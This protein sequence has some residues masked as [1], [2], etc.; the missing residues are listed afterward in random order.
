MS[1]LPEIH[2]TALGAVTPVGLTAA[3]SCAALRA[4]LSNKQEIGNFAVHGEEFDQQPAVGG[5]VPLEWLDGEP[6]PELW[7]GHERW[8][9]KDPPVLESIIETGCDRLERLAAPA[10]EDL[11]AHPGW[12]VE[13]AGKWPD[14]IG[15]Y[16]GLDD[17]EDAEAMGRLILNQ[18]PGPCRPVKVKVKGRAAGLSAL[19][20]AI[21]DLEAGQ[22]TAAIIGGLD[23]LIR[24]HSLDRL[25][26]AGQLRSAINNHGII[27]GEA[28]GFV[29]L[30]TG[31][32]IRSRGGLPLA[33]VLGHGSALE[34]TTGTDEPSQAKGLTKA[35][36]AAVQ[37]AGLRDG[38]PLVVC[39]LNGDRYRAI[40][41]GLTDPR[42]LRH[43][44]GNVRT[45]H[46]ADC[47]G[48]CGA[49]SGL[50]DLIW[51][52][53]AMNKNYARHDQV[54]VWGASDNGTRAAVVLGCTE[55]KD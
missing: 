15:L 2:I 53:V 4:G 47:T 8:Q 46:P 41:W 37:Q 6:E 33:R 35:V 19:T 18:L 16:L 45:W 43:L 34:S 39:D 30:E 23:S 52:T 27:P 32:S 36:R 14:K 49:A 42:A 20:A 17:H 22:V 24:P 12:P 55:Q 7:P 51:G 48:D 10:I 13:W 31:V 40:E 11:L 1:R 44:G 26:R 50:V 54:L 3:A 21:E 28:V 25:E 38:P 5:R 29:L 9:L